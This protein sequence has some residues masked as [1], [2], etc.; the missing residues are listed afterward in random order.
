MA[1]KHSMAV[2]LDP[3]MRKQNKSEIAGSQQNLQHKIIMWEQNSGHNICLD[4]EI[5]IVTVPFG[6]QVFQ[7]RSDQTAHTPVCA[8]QQW[9][10]VR[11]T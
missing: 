1:S 9:T 7:N 4:N 2:A 3:G 11:L 5:E 6:I 10:P 8:Q